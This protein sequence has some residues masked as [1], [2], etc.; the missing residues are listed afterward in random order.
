MAKG[1]IER[2]REALLLRP[3]DISP[4]SSGLEVIGVFNPGAIRTDDG[5]ALLCR[6]AESV[7]ET[8]AGQMPSPRVTFNDDEPK[9]GIDWFDVADQRGDP[10]KVYRG[11]GNIRLSFISHLRL[12][13]L[14][15]DGFRV[16]SIDEVP[17]LFP[18]DEREEFGIEDPRITAFGD[19]FYITYVGVGTLTGIATML[20]STRDFR[21]FRRHGIIFPALNKDVV[22][23]P[24]RIGGKH[25]A[26]HRPVPKL[27]FTNPNIATAVS[28]DLEHWGDTRCLFGPNEAGWDS[29]KIGGGPPPLLTPKGWL[30]IYHG[31]QL[32][33]P[34]DNVGRYCV[35][36]ALL[37][38]A[39]PLH[40]LART[41]E[42]LLVPEQ[43]YELTGFV[44]NVLFPT[45]IVQNSPDTIL[46]FNG[47]ADTGV[48]VIE[49]SLDD[50][51][52]AL[53]VAT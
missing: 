38:A 5:I 19:R 41:E 26:L 28:P 15:R 44:D 48:S 13:K 6:V 45:G 25:W 51:F 30:V 7:R 36:A 3:A 49:L 46:L 8:R 39:N 47:V 42:P 37:D 16:E 18:S 40:V 9:L 2:K 34:E 21:T 10:R 4:S 1:R 24:E 52:E 14:S 27:Y 33:Q 35:G 12:V 43:D 32:L 20:A 22:I 17:T 50:I 11:G 53:R 29:S 23:F 31:V